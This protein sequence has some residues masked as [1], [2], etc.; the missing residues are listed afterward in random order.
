MV[1]AQE[2]GV[3]PLNAAVHVN[4]GGS[5]RLLQGDDSSTLKGAPR[6]SL[7]S[8]PASS[9]KCK[10]PRCKGLGLLQTCRCCRTLSCGSSTLRSMTMPTWPPLWARLRRQA[11]PQSAALQ[12]L[13]SLGRLQEL[14]M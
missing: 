11:A 5:W 6:S 9:A 1:V 10:T 2:L 8:I 12:A 13:C 4:R 14:E 7:L 3:H